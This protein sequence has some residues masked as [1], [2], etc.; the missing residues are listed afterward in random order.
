M[1]RFEGVFEGVREERRAAACRI[2]SLASADSARRALAL[3]ERLVAERLVAE[4]L[5]AE[6]ALGVPLDI[7]LKGANHGS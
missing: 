6:G 7:Y 1:G 5:V 3:A 2:R 4:R